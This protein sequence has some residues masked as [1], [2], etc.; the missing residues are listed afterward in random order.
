VLADRF[1]FACHF[2][3]VEVPVYNLVIAKGGLKMKEAK[4]GEISPWKF[5]A[6]GDRDTP[7][8]GM[9]IP[10]VMTPNGP[11]AVFQGVDMA[12]FAISNVFA[13]GVD[14]PVIDKTGLTGVYN[15]TLDFSW[16]QLTAGTSQAGASEPAGPDIFTALQQQLGLKLEPARG[17]VSHL[18]V[19]HLERPSEN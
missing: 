2:V 19:D 13:Y 12:S 16:Q 7:N 17:Q 6:P 11:L 4:P 14:R 15:F 3:N 1:K 18:V 8:A 9:G 10:T 5:H